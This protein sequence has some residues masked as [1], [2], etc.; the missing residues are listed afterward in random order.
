MLNEY[1]N[2]VQSENVDIRDCNAHVGNTGIVDQQS[3]NLGLARLAK[4]RFQRMRR[5]QQRSA[6]SG[7][8]A[9]GWVARMA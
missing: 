3:A 1:L 4:E 7:S 6:F 5:R 8:I 2:K 9:R